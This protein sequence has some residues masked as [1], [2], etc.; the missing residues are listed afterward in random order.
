MRRRSRRDW[1]GYKV[2][3]KIIRLAAAALALFAAPAT[4]QGFSDAYNFLKAVREG[5]GSKVSEL[6][7]VPGSIVVNAKDRAT[8][9]G[10]LHIVARDRN[11]GWL[12]FLIGK[13]ARPD[14]QNNEGMTPLAIATQIGWAEGAQL[15]LDRRASVDLANVRGETPLILAVQNRDL[16]M[17]R[18]LLGRGA[19]PKRTDR[20]AG[21]S[22]L[23]YA[24]KDARSAAIVK[25]L[26]AP[27]TPA[28]A[29]QG[30]GL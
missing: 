4:A 3:Q 24:R 6:A 2:D 27:V 26:E 1:Q 14:L 7:S 16:A 10:A 21:Y 9:D 8:G 11:L 23:D 25:L 13:G 28:K 30:P 20:V 29:A 17:V 15:L 12:A 22:A 5:D 19:N 18:L